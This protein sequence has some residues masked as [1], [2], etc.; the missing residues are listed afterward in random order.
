[1]K[2]R[3]L[4]K[5]GAAAGLYGVLP[6]SSA[7]V[8][9]SGVFRHSTNASAPDMATFLP[10]FDQTM[11]NLGKHSVA[12]QLLP[13][14]SRHLVAEG[15][16]ELDRMSRAMRV[17]YVTGSLH[18][19]P[20]ESQLDPG[21]QQRMRAYAPEM[22]HTVHE[23]TDMIRGLPADRR[24][25]LQKRLRE[26]PALPAQLGEQIKELAAN[27]RMRRHRG[28]Q[29]VEGMKINGWRLRK[30]PPS[31]LIDEYMDKVDRVAPRGMSQ[32]VLHRKIAAIV[33]SNAMLR[34]RMAAMS[35]TA[36]GSADKSYAP[37]TIAPT[38]APAKPKKEGYTGL[39]VMGFGGILFGSGLVV[40][41]LGALLDADGVIG[42]GAVMTVIGLPIVLLGLLILIIEAIA[43]G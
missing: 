29:V 42:V 4:L 21:L 6:S 1:M 40:M 16:V 3:D 36:A 22:E 37:G 9:P 35:T 33:G 25:H 38:P 41:G 17:L 14:T 15:S 20:L 43:R 13:D 34:A 39:K 5:V 10:A 23:I 12:A 28:N 7:C 26:D 18:D 31:M 32:A 19:L 30:Q 2:R 8:S 24:K 27:A 11:A